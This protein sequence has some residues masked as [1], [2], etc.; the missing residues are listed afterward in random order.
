MLLGRN[1]TAITRTAKID[2][3]ALPSVPA[4]LPSDI[5]ERRP[6]IKQAEF[7]LIAANARIGAAK[8]LYYP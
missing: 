4:G 5:L 2:G 3:L 6:D 8:A 7:N 1:P